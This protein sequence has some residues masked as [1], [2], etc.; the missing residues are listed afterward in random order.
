MDVDTCVHLGM[1]VDIGIDLD[2]RVGRIT[3]EMEQGLNSASSLSLIHP[4][5]W[6]N[7]YGLK[8]G[9]G[10]KAIDIFIS[11]DQTSPKIVCPY[12]LPFLIS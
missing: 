7:G 4:P 6:Q 10:R 3:T 9:R 5:N 8:N 1:D 11:N 12:F 2:P